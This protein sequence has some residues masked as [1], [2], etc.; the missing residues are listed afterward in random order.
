MVISF[1]SKSGEGVGSGVLCSAAF[2]LNGRE[3]KES[4]RSELLSMNF[5]RCMLGGCKINIGV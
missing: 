3:A 2:E 1:S 4:E 5:L